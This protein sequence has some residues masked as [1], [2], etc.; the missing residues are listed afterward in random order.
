MALD[1]VI[2]NILE[3]ARQE[4]GARLREAET[5]RARILQEAD[6]KI[7]RIQKAEE[8]ERQDALLRIRTQELSSAELEAK[9]IV[10]NKRKE[11]LG[12]TFEE[13]LRE[14]SSLPSRERSVLY[15]KILADGKSV[16]P[17]PKVYCPKGEADLLTGLRGAS[18]LT[19]VDLEPGLIFE[20]EDG[21]VRLDFRFQTILEGIWEKELKNV[22]NILFE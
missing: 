2:D 14:L 7:E 20:S 16:I 11:I 17:R 21:T 6:Q 22:S 15:K 9:K 10:L 12:Q 1:K 13:V 18:S 8:K 19:E 3:S 5:E 4:A